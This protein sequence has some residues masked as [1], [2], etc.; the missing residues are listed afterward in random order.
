MTFESNLIR[1]V[2]NH[3]GP[4]ITNGKFGGRV[5]DDLIKYASWQFT[6]DDLP[7]NGTNKMIYT[8]P[9]GSKLLNAWFQV[10]TAFAGGTSYDIGLL[11]SAGATVIATD[12]LWDL[13]ATAEIDATETVIDSLA[14]GG[15]NSGTCLI[16]PLPAAGQLS[17][18]ATGTFT[19]GAGR[20][21]I[22]YLTVQP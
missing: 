20:I 3:Y 4:R 11:D 19:A 16:V 18:V 17:V 13:I 2:Q 6:Y 15:T 1:G 14:H 21:V 9:L 22:Q 5:D 10:E 8:I 7:T 12:G